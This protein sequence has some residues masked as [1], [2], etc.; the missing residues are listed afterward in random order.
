MLRRTVLFGLALL[1]GCGNDSPS[2]DAGPLDANAV[3]ARTIDAGCGDRLAA[4]IGSAGG[5]LEHCAGARLVVPPGALDADVELSITRVEVDVDPQAPLVLAGPAFAF[6]APSGTSLALGV[7]VVLPH[8]GGDRVEIAALI[9]GAW[10]TFEACGVTDSTIDQSVGFFGT[11][12]ALRDPTTYPDSGP[13]GLG[14]GTIEYTFGTLSETLEIDPSGY[15]IDEDP[16][17]RRSL[18]FVFRRSDEDG[19]RQVD[20]RFVLEADGTLLPVQ[21]AHADTVL[22]EIWSADELAHPGDT[23]IAIT[24]DEAGA[25]EGTIDATLHLGDEERA[26]HA[27]FDASAEPWRYP[28]ERVCGHPEG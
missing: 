11:F 19:L 5:T 3:D 8:D 12:A 23:T 2:N 9:D 10:E 26:F 24:R 13:S 14:A 25:L 20:L 21:L 28:P 4:T 16:G 7:E 22:S 6:G 15:G 18:T 1:A 17:A 27:T